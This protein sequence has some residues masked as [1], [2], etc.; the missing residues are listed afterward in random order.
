MQL[1]FFKETGK[2]TFNAG[3]KARADI[4]YIMTK[5]GSKSIDVSYAY[6]D[7]G[8]IHK[9]FG[10]LSLALKLLF[11][12][13]GTALLV[14]YP[15]RQI[16]TLLSK[17]ARG[18]RIIYLIHDLEGLR[19]QDEEQQRRDIATLDKAYKI[20]AHNRAMKEYLVGKGIGEDKIV[21]LGVFDY[22]AD[23]DREPNID[24]SAQICFAGNLNKSVFLDK[25]P[26]DI[27]VNLYGLK[28]DD[29]EFG[30]NMRYM[31]SFPS[32]E[33][34]FVLDGK[35]ALVWDG[36]SADTCTGLMGEY[37]RYNNPHKLSLY[38]C[39]GKPVI[40]WRQAAIA[41]FVIEQGIGVAVEGLSDLSSVIAGIDD[42]QYGAMQDR[43]MGLRSQVMQ[44][45]FFGR[46]LDKALG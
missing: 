34:P 22:I 7:I 37:T 17:L 14:Q 23:R 18:K 29:R 3:Y 21:T 2:E 45:E 30:D 1:I 10:Y 43:V 12:P 44:G 25:L 9:A 13:K 33:I 42:E 41:E 16:S 6:A 40:V 38:I 39:T 31:G 11:I 24:Y 46:A 4:D 36:D 8:K 32:D 15:C 35:Y 20:I 26:Q 27:T 5:R 19:R 28:D